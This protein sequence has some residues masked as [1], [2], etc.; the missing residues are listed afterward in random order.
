M[1]T[2]KVPLLIGSVDVKILVLCQDFCEECGAMW[3]KKADIVTRRMEIDMR[4][5]DQILRGI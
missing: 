5:P 2:L 4:S 3:V 1:D